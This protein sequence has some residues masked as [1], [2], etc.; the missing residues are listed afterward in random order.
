[1][2]LL[3]FPLCM[4]FRFRLQDLVNTKA[5]VTSIID[6]TSIEIDENIIDNIEKI[7]N[8]TNIENTSIISN[9]SIHHNIDP[10]IFFYFGLFMW[11]RLHV[12]E[13]DRLYSWTY[14]VKNRTNQFIF[15]FMIIF[16]KNI[17]RVY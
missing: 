5:I 3:L 16:W 15:I 12:N 9:I 10:N 11:N 14:P 2:N 13:K 6:K 7:I 17:E 4:A 8:Y 1:M